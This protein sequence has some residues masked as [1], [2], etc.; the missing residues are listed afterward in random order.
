MKTDVIEIECP[1]CGKTI[2]SNEDTCPYCCTHLE[3]NDINDLENVANGREVPEKICIPLKEK[4]EPAKVEEPKVSE[5]KGRFDKLFG[6]GK[7]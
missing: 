4:E 5:K 2:H 6:R 3:F 1:N 7:K